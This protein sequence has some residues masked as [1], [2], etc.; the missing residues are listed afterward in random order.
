L[1]SVICHLGDLNQVVLNLV[2][3]AAHAI[4][5]VVGKSEDK[6]LITVKTWQAGEDAVIS[7]ADTGCG[8]AES[9]RERIF[10]PFFTTKDVG[11]GTGQGLA[12]A[13][14]AIVSKHG[15]TLIFETEVGK[16]T[17][18]EIRIPISGKKRVTKPLAA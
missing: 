10:D 3:N 4:A 9:V 11:G 5:E 12:V 7:V 6:G 18:F 17:R 13:R 15:G 14:N 8:I 16:G 1:P 2:V